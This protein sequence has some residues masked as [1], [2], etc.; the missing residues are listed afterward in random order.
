MREINWGG[1]STKAID[2]MYE[3]AISFL[4]SDVDRHATNGR[5]VYSKELHF[6]LEVVEERVRRLRNTVNAMMSID[7]NKQ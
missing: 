5:Q 6:H 7:D 3:E 4:K 1:L 2:K